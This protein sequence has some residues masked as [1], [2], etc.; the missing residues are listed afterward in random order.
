VSGETQSKTIEQLIEN[1][2]TFIAT[3][4]SMQN[5][6]LFVGLFPLVLAVGIFSI[7]N[8]NTKPTPNAKRT[9]AAG[10]SLSCQKVF[11]EKNQLP[12]A[13]SSGYIKL[14][15]KF[16]DYM[17]SNVPTD[18][19]ARYRAV[20]ENIF[21]D[22]KGEACGN[23]FGALAAIDPYPIH[24]MEAELTGSLRNANGFKMSTF[25]AIRQALREHYSFES[26]VNR[27]GSEVAEFLKRLPKEMV[28]QG[29][30]AEAR[31]LEYAMLIRGN[32]GFM[33]PVV[34]LSERHYQGVA[35]L[36]ALSQTN[37][38]FK[39]L[40]A[41]VAE[42]ATKNGTDILNAKGVFQSTP[43]EISR[44]QLNTDPKMV[45][46]TKAVKKAIWKKHALRLRR[47]DGT[48]ENPMHGFDAIAQAVTVLSRIQVLETL[49]TSA[50][51]Q[52]EVSNIL[53]TAV[54]RISFNLG[55]SYIAQTSALNP[56]APKIMQMNYKVT[57]KL[58]MPDNE[59]NP[60]FVF[61]A[62]ESLDPPIVS[63]L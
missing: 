4:A 34:L 39:L 38:G 45:E 37:Q 27:L 50:S 17:L 54:D 30:E 47:E 59:G 51:Q 14:E 53:L 29:I 2:G 5:K 36:F 21:G 9:L 12:I 1:I 41:R 3:L 52:V 48:F 7:K 8:D 58:D 43:V 63:P 61:E 16:F 46:D 35:D 13:D 49:E 23:P 26:Q 22:S 62:V 24:G 31:R 57:L 60:R 18:L 40:R 11:E 42:E 25:E 44:E 33:E 20:S 55:I 56:N 6:N 28:E 15:D 32:S 10:G 19:V